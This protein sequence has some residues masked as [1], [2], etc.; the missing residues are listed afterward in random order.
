M[1]S[2]RSKPPMPGASNSLPKSRLLLKFAGTRSLA[3][4][5]L[6]PS[7]TFDLER[8]SRDRK[9]AGSALTTY[10]TINGYRF[11]YL[12]DPPKNG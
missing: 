11:G 2:W 9:G 10:P 12:G 8:Q 4:A 3:V 5:A 6:T 7:L 1:R